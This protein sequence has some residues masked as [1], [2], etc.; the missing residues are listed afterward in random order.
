MRTFLL[1][2]L[3][4]CLSASMLLAMPQL[5]QQRETIWIGSDLTLGMSE[6]AVSTKL[7][8]SYSL[9][10]E[11]APPIWQ[12]KGITSLWF[13]QEKGEQR[14]L[15]GTLFFASGKLHSVAKPLLSDDGDTVEF[16][17]QLYFAMRDLEH[18]GDS[19]CVIQTESDDVPD[20]ANKS[21]NLKC[22]M[23]SIVITVQKM[24]GNNETVDL[25][26]ELSAR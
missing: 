26:E 16:G 18:E 17:R 11:E 20:Y 23:K 6:D 14:T 3:L 5:A 12:A 21:A 10:K 19:H 22:G 1:G 15:L 7:A 25:H 8:G 2:L 4:G 24:K 13:V 9:R